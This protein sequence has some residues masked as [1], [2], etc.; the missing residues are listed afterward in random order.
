MRH[1][2]SKDGTRI[3]FEQSG[4]GPALIMVVGA[5]N[6]RTTGMPLGQLLEPRFT[7]F[8]Y[9]RRGRG[10]SGD[11]LPYTVERE[12]EDLDALIHEAGGSAYVF[13][14]SSGAVLAMRAAAQ[15]LAITRMALYE[16]PLLLDPPSDDSKS[17]G[18]ISTANGQR[19]EASSSHAFSPQA[20]APQLAEL[21]AQGRRGDAVELFQT[22]GVGIPMEI[23][24]QTRNAPFRPALERMAHTLVYEMTIL[25]D[26]PSPAEIIASAA[27]PT[28]LMAGAQSPMFLQDAVKSLAHVLPNG[29]FRIL[30]GQTHDI[31]PS[32]VAPLVEEFFTS[33][34]D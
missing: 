25:G 19:I 20:L 29:Q 1:V 12:I 14:Y 4:Q 30:E 27:A 17:T 33:E 21:I 9:D 8:N 28:L 22:Q 11:T 34:Q 10:D 31:I 6:D 7:V 23:V 2:I 5:F 16:P 3:T 26:M 18:H 13:G 32:V 15:G 24:V